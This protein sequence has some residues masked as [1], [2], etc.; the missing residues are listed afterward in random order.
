MHWQSPDHALTIRRHGTVEYDRNGRNICDKH[1]IKVA[2]MKT[3]A[4]KKKRS[5][6]LVVKLQQEQVGLSNLKMIQHQELT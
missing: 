1:M 3:R 5:N 4:K 6:L 2:Q